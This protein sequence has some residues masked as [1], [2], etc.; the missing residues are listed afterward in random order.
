VLRNVILFGAILAMSATAVS[1]AEAGPSPVT[2]YVAQ[3]GRDDWSG[4]LAAP[5]RGR[6]DG[7]FASLARAR[8]AIRELKR[9]Q[10]GLKQAVTVCLRQGAYYLDEPFVLTPEDSG[11]AGCPITYSAYKDEKPIVSGGRLITGWR[12]TEVHGRQAWAA[13][14]PE[15]AAGKWSFREL[16]VNHERR[17]RT[18]LPKEGFYHIA[19]LLEDVSKVQWSQGQDRFRFAND[20]LK[21]W[22]NLQDV[23]IVS[24]QLWVESRMPIASVDAAEH[25]VTLGKRS[26][27][28][29]T[30][31]FQTTGARY[32]VENVFEALDTPG[33][34]YLERTSGTLYYLPKER[35]EP[36]TCEVVAPRLAQVVRFEGDAEKQQWV[37]HVRLKGLSFMH[38][39]W[40]LPPDSAGSSQAAV[41]VPGAIY[42]Q[43][44]RSCA[45]EGCTVAH[46]GTY[47][48]ELAGGCEGN[49]IARNA[50]FDLGA[51]GV[52]VGHGTARTTVSDNEIHDGGHI[53][54]SAVGVWIGNSGH[55][56]V[57][58]NHI[59][60]LYYT[61]I[62]V[63]WTWGYGPSEAV[64]N[65]IEYNHIHHVG[66]GLLSDLGGIYTLG[67]SPGTVLR[68][69]LIH[70]CWSHTY[71][72]WGI[73][74]D[75]GS[76]NIVVE[77]NVVFRTKTGGF[78]QHYGR[79]NLIENN[80][81]ALA[82]ETQI[83]RS[84]EEEHRS[85]TFQRNIVYW[86][87]GELL[88]STWKNGNFLLDH[89]L[90][91]DTRRQPITFAGKSLEEW[92]AF[93]QDAH[94]VVADPGFADPKKG[95]F[96]L[97]PD[98][99]A[100]ALGFKPIEI[101]GAGPRR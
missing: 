23:E 4:K 40:A 66:R 56:E 65:R 63:G 100:L 87:E 15:V 26:V 35:E 3:T 58:H 76:T 14:V 57:A 89:N 37:E 10:G 68:Y 73:Y 62:S 64:A 44:A 12:K 36:R 30:D 24:L 67:V 49:T 34:W 72:G 61:G 20:D 27:F 83:M 79:E 13:K 19:G 32:Y 97:A 90:Y 74:L 81:F 7:P 22:A 70:D 77:N 50:L 71:G 5:N 28:R 78:H 45:V 88:G 54:H 46:A 101:S 91:W 16:F 80:V 25:V 21:A 9:E 94:S 43:G 86:S 39:E 55:N 52:K 96:T 75:E 99:P 95:D 8:D 82:K 93:G 33:Q 85:F 6:T 59:H 18:R 1:S 69:N 31:D 98:S 38:A 84:R 2:F 92:R 42:W 51:G 47:A 60:D 41:S 17:P 53:F 29:L 48:I 11:T